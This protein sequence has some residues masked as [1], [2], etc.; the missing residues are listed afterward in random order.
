MNCNSYEFCQML[1]TTMNEI[2]VLLMCTCMQLLP[3][4][5]FTHHQHHHQVEAKNDPQLFM[6]LFLKVLYFN[7]LP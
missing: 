4:T 5:A 2:L 3:C 7:K 6:N 1:W